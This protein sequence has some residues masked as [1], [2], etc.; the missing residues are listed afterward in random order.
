MKLILSKYDHSVMMH[1]K[2]T[3]MSLGVEKLL[4][5]DRLNINEFVHLEL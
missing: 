3:R 5:F 1:V 4:P 2:F